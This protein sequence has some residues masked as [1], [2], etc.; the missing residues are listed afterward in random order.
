MSLPPEL[1]VRTTGGRKEKD[2]GVQHEPLGASV[3]PEGSTKEELR[4][5]QVPCSLP[6]LGK[7]A[8][9]VLSP[10]ILPEETRP[11]FTFSFFIL[12]YFFGFETGSHGT[13]TGLGLL[14]LIFAAAVLGL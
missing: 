1:H 11:F 3:V 13:Q 9:F 5:D 12:F 6:F 2:D 7:I 8:E 4:S 10:N 14:I